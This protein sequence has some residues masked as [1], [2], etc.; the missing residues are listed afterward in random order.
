MAAFSTGEYDNESLQV[1][2]LGVNFMYIKGKVFSPSPHLLLGMLTTVDA[3][4]HEL[5]SNGRPTT[6][7]LSL[8]VR[9]K[10]S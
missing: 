9:T 8:S 10:T 1:E 2:E 6:A 5:V 3:Y 4:S 7:L